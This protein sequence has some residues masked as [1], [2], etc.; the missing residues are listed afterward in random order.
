MIRAAWLLATLPL[1]AQM[2]AP[3]PLPQN[4]IGAGGGYSQM[5]PHATVWLSYAHLASDAQQIYL[6]GT[7][8]FLLMRG[9][10]PTYLFE[11]G[12]SKVLLRAGRFYVLGIAT[13]GVA[14]SGTATTAAFSG[15]GMAVYRFKNGATIEFIARQLKAGGMTGPGYKF[16]GGWTW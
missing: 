6:W 15:E 13:A 4:W 1:A 16:G 10:V 5:A 11:P 7:Y 9:K 14:Q 2:T 8:D 3:A 12:V